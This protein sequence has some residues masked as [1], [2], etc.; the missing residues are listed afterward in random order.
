VLAFWALIAVACMN[1]AAQQSYEPEK[2]HIEVGILYGRD[3]VS[4]GPGAILQGTLGRL[5][6]YGFA[7]TSSY[8]YSSSNGLRA[9]LRDRTLGFGVQ[10]RIARL[11]RHFSINAFG[12]AAYYG[13]H[14]HATY[15]E[16][17]HTVTAEYRE[18]D[19]DPLVTIGPEIDYKIA[20]GFRVAM[21]PGK[22]FGHSFA[23][24]TA[25]GFSI[26]V[27][28]LIDARDAGLHIAKGIKKLA[29]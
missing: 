13:S 29:R 10:Y 24:Q 25:G 27:G 22:D 18:S 1:H 16:P 17:D 6:L 26:R 8:G 7:G 4:L 23:A 14:I 12:E 15:F 11:G 20:E 21:R 2:P 28:V 9:N 3:G 5:G 19:R